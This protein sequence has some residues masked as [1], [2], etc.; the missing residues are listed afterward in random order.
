MYKKSKPS[1]KYSNPLTNNTNAVIFPSPLSFPFPKSQIS[2]LHHH[3]HHLKTMKPNMNLPILPERKLLIAISSITILAA[4][5]LLLTITTTTTSPF[6]CTQ[7]NP[8]HST[9]SPIQLKSILHYATSRTVPQQ[10][11][12]EITVSFNVLKTISPCNFLVFGLGHDS[13]M[14]ASFNANGKT[15]FLEEDEKWFKTVVNDAKELKAEVVKY[16]TKLSEADELMKTYRSEPECAPG[17]SYI[18]GNTRCRLVT[19]WLSVCSVFKIF[20]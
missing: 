8:F 1:I 15:L 2:D 18:K 5:F 6:F 13:L 11:F 9:P 10:S 7:S 17:K 20:F 19:V 12:S 14:W 3:H 16:R 4:A